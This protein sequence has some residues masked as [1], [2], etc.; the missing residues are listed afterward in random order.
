MAIKRFDRTYVPASRER[1]LRYR[2]DNDFRDRTK[3]SSRDNY[4][5]R[6]GVKFTSCAYSLEFLDQLGKKEVV[7]YPDGVTEGAHVLYL[8]DT[9]RALQKLYQTV[10]RWVSTGMIPRP[11]LTA[12]FEHAKPNRVYHINEIRVL[13]EEIGKHEE[14]Y[15]YYRKDHAEVRER[16]EQRFSE[17]RKALGHFEGH[18]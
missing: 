17:V 3:K 5:R 11:L 1:K 18:V 4:R 14:Q 10:F 2:L 13:V 8:V 6:S 12:K 7:K 15:S 16:I 9:S